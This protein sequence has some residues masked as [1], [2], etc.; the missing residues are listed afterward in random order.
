MQTP[1][2]WSG[3]EDAEPDQ[4]DYWRGNFLKNNPEHIR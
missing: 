2:M 4:F 3:L 1:K